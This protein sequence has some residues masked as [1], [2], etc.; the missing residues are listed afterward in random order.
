MS[1][2]G[3][4]GRG[5][6]CVSVSQRHSLDHQRLGVEGEGPQQLG[7]DGVMLGPGLEDQ[8]SVSRELRLPHLLH[9]P[10]TCSNM[11]RNER[12][13]SNKVAQREE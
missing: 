6:V 13:Y 7:G 8:A 9:R 10:L 5:C 3:V 2:G 12:R 4:E 1:G 11:G